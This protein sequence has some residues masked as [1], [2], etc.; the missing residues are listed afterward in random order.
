MTKDCL[1]GHRQLSHETQDRRSQ[2]RPIGQIQ[3]SH[4]T[5]DK[6][7]Q[8]SLEVSMSN[9][10]DPFQPTEMNRLW[11]ERVVRYCQKRSPEALDRVFDAMTRGCTLTEGEWRSE[12]VILGTL[13][14]IGADLDT[15]AWFCG[16]MAGEINR[17]EDNQREHL[18]LTHLSKRLAE[19]GL[20]P[21]LDF[22]PY[23]GQRLVILSVEK[24]AALPPELRVELEAKFDLIEKSGEEL[25]QV[26][27][28]LIQELTVS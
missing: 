5:Q 10:F 19:C 20:Q 22:V 17:R 21:F 7:L 3:M 2:D 15:L 6:A 26:N 4:E 9:G 14:Q 28:A 18:P 11:V 27:D 23:P 16:Y 8:N 24:V 25:Q 12:K 1:I 13:A